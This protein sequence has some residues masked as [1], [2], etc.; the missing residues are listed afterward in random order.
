MAAHTPAISI[1]QVITQLQHIIDISIA[2]KSR[3]GFFAALY[4]KVTVRVKEAIDRGEFDDNARMEQFDVQFANRYIRAWHEWQNNEQPTAPWDV[5]FKAAE[6]RKFLVIQ[7][8][9]LGMNAHINLDLGLVA[10]EISTPETLQDLQAD[11][12]RINEILGAM[13][14]EVIQAL[15][16]VS[17]ILSMMGLHNGNETIL[18]QFSL[19]NARDGA[20]GFAE[21]V[22]EAATGE[23]AEIV[24]VRSGKIARLGESLIKSS[25]LLKLTLWFIRLFEWNNPAKVIAVL[26]EFQKKFIHVDKDGALSVSQNPR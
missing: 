1:D 9:L 7:H 3:A 6:K 14:Y 10:A 22:S 19:T 21:K 12:N 5:A 23:K 11:F 17:P 24:E 25:G 20:W 2:Q 8:L 13:T 16:Q 18:I 26:H 4:H 15:N